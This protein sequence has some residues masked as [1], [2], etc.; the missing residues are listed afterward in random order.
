M[1][2]RPLRVVKV[3]GSLLAF[4]ELRHELREW[5][6]Q[7]SSAV[8]VF[9]AGGGAAADLVREAAQRFDLDEEQSHWLAIKAM[10]LTAN[11]LH[12]LLPEAAI[13]DSLAAMRSADDDTWLIVEPEGFLRQE[14]ERLGSDILPHNWDTT[15]D[16]IAARIAEALDADELVLLKSRTLPGDGSWLNAAEEGFVD[17]YFPVA[18]AGLRHVR[19]VNLRDVRLSRDEQNLIPSMQAI[20]P[21]AASTRSRA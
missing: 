9:V 5:I 10:G 17:P 14:A 19:A 13:I 6:D 12:V 21:A 2:T 7:Q 18:A 15:S 4:D 8:T 20:S 11:L 16:S 3:G 1:S